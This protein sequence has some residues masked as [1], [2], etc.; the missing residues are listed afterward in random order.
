MSKIKSAAEM[1]A[2]GQI[3]FQ[4]LEEACGGKVTESVINYA[5]AYEHEF[6]LHQQLN[7]LQEQYEEAAQRTYALGSEL[8]S[9][10]S[11]HLCV[12]EVDENGNVQPATT[13]KVG[14]SFIIPAQSFTERIKK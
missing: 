8:E 7:K 3:S 13:W 5:R 4:Q 9:K 12:F 11:K 14:A 2:L 6:N 10:I 1:Y